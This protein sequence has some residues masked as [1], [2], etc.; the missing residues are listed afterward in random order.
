M[1]KRL[2]VLTLLLAGTAAFLQPTAAYAQSPYNRGYYSYNDRGYR[3][4]YYGS[5]DFD[6]HAR[7]EREERREERREREWRRQEWR[8]HERW[9]R[10]SSYAPSYGYYN[11]YYGYPY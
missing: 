8:E 1:I 3:D 4:G 2:G 10:R 7:H 9:E 6:R 5:R 11:P